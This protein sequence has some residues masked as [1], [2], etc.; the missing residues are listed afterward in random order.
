MMQ[1][2]NFFVQHAWYDRQRECTGS[3]R[4]IIYLS[5]L[6][7]YSPH[8]Y[9]SALYNKQTMEDESCHMAILNADGVYVAVVAMLSLCLK[10]ATCGWYN[11]HSTTT[12]P[13]AS[14]VC[15]ITQSRHMAC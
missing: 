3:Y 14:E 6:I 11:K 13:P 5:L 10:L 1:W 4:L 2:C 7:N 15:N 9:I 12:S 8:H